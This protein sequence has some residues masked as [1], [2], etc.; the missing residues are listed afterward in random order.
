MNINILR[1]SE[2]N[3]LGRRKIEDILDLKSEG[4]AD[5]INRNADRTFKNLVAIMDALEAYKIDLSSDDDVTGNLGVSHLNSGEDAS[6]ATFWRGDGTWSPPAS[7]LNDLF[8]TK[9]VTFIETDPTTNAPAGF[10]TT[11]TATGT[12]IAAAHGDDGLWRSHTTSTVTAGTAGWAFSST[13]I[14]RAEHSPV[15]SMRFKTGSDVT[16]LRFW[17]GLSQSVTGA[18]INAD[19]PAGTRMIALRYSTPG[20]DAGWRGVAQTAAGA[21]SVTGSLGAVTADT[22]YDIE[23]RV[24]GTTSVEFTVNG[25]SETLTSNIPTSS[26][27]ATSNMGVVAL[28]INASAGGAGTARTILLGRAFMQSL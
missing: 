16:G 20:G 14:Y 24:T 15:L 18:T 28:V 7:D 3:P 6:S 13:A 26:A 19:L 12:T 11:T 17:I 21:Q 5:R 23:I 2:G 4:A 25:V 8:A 1:G 22:V 10:G 9:R 27:I